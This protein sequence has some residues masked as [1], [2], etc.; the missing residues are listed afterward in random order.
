MTQHEIESSLLDA[1][2]AA[3]QPFDGDL[4]YGDVIRYG[5][6]RAQWLIIHQL[7]SGHVAAYFGDWK[8]GSN[9][10]FKSWINGRG[11]PVKG[12]DAE[13]AQRELDQKRKEV[14]AK[15]ERKAGQAAKLA[16]L[17]VEHAATTGT[18]E[19]LTR[20][21]IQP[22]GLHFGADEYGSFVVVPMMDITTGELKSAQRIYADGSKKFLPGTPLKSNALAHLIGADLATLDTDILWVSEG[23]ATAATIHEI[24]GQPVLVAFNSSNLVKVA[25]AAHERW[26]EITTYIAADNDQ[27]RVGQPVDPDKPDGPK[28]VN[29]G[30]VAAQKAVKVGNAKVFAPDFTNLC[31]EQECRG[32][33]EG[34]TDF[35][36]LF[37]IAGA[38]VTRRQLSKPWARESEP[39]TDAEQQAADAVIPLADRFRVIEQPEPGKAPG[40]WYRPPL[41]KD[42]HQPADVWLCAPLKITAATRDDDSDNHGSLLEFRD[43]HGHA[44]SWAMPREMLEDRR[45]YRRV[46]RRLGLAMN[47]SSEGMQL[48]QT[49]LDVTVSKTKALCVDRIGWHRG[50]YVLPDKNIGDEGGERLI[51]QTF[52]HRSEGYKQSVSSLEQWRESVSKL[53]IGNSRLALAV[54]TAF[55][56][57]LLELTGAE[58]GGIH[59]RGDSSLGKTTALTV[60]ATV[61]G[62]PSR[63]ER[64]R[65]T[66]NALEGVALAHNDNL[67]CLDELREVDPREAGAISYM[68]A[69]GT[70]KRRGQPHGGVRQRLT[71]RL[72]FLSSGELSLEQH[73]QETGKKVHA[74]QEVRLVDIPADAGTGL[75]LF[76]NIHQSPSSKHFADKLNEVAQQHYGFAGRAFAAEIVDDA[77]KIKKAAGT[78]RDGFVERFV[79]DG[80]AGQVYRVASRFGLIAAAGELA[81][82]AGITGWP[83]GEAFKSAGVC[84][85]AWIRSRGGYGS[86]EVERALAQVRLFIERFGEARFKPWVKAD[87]ETCERCGGSGHVEYSYQKGICFDCKGNGKITGETEPN[88]PIYDRAG[89][90]RATG[91]GRTEY[92]ILAQLVKREIASGYDAVWLAQIL[93]ERGLLTPDGN[94]RPTRTERLPG[95]GPTRVYRLLPEIEPEQE[96]EECNHVTTE[97]TKN[98]TP[99]SAENIFAN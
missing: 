77:D 25:K 48:L 83:E 33:G 35:N 1:L 81:T 14:E 98:I 80:S 93:L 60:A 49:Y 58:S 73:V 17:I 71:W 57:P 63:I 45:E 10:E 51:L 13:A 18:S 42:G 32:T 36:D 99:P 31:D 16:A 47:G 86:A 2:A 90:R 9:H 40:L 76:E 52:D 34:P 67:L 7:S 43:L 74:G 68:L 38:E 3:G 65:A 12:F 44:Q 55:A 88:R 59:Y 8:Q 69:N 29:A 4:V 50:V 22:H 54:S 20:K 41:T 30:L 27:W 15:A 19:Y 82:A 96:E 61:W 11:Q 72:L 78:L 75:G 28:K 87:G 24:T 85:E 6:K 23:Y 62:E 91:D 26:P 70:G 21:Q 64:W 56:A 53:C 97:T 95:M 66:G 5:R 37:V 39:V 79:P 94:G 89:F 46:L 92:Y 84:F